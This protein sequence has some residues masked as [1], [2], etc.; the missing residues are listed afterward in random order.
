ME[1]HEKH[2]RA[3]YKTVALMTAEETASLTTHAGKSILQQAK[4]G[5]RVQAFK[6]VCRFE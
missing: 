5:L 6:V 3:N 4:K 1:R 2:N